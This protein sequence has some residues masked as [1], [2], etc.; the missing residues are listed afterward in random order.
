MEFNNQYLMSS[1]IL[2]ID[3]AYLYIRNKPFSMIINL[4]YL[5]TSETISFLCMI[6]QSPSRNS[7][8]RRSSAYWHIRQ[9]LLHIDTS[10]HEIIAIKFLFL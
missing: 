4:A 5:F 8:Y 1:H 10:E 6:I 9:K 7:H 3:F 2:F